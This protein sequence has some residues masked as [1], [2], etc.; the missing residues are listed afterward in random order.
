MPINNG[1]VFSARVTRYA[2]WEKVAFGTIA[3]LFMEGQIQEAHDVIDFCVKVGLPTCFRDLGIEIDSEKLEM[4]ARHCMQEG[5][6]AWNM[7]P[8]LT[9]E[10]LINGMLE[11]DAAGMAAKGYDSLMLATA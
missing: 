1:L 6:S 3:Q 2:A 10:S 7:G 4:I 5:T 9:E 11:A 8:D